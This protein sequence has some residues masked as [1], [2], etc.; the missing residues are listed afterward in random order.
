M[1]LTP[2]QGQEEDDDPREQADNPGAQQPA[3]EKGH[4]ARQQ[5]PQKGAENRAQHAAHDEYEQRGHAQDVIQGHGREPGEIRLRL[6]Q[7]FAL[8]EPAQ[9]IHP[10]LDATGEIALLEA[11][12][13]GFGDDPLGDGIRNR[14]LQAIA[15]L[16]AQ[17]PVVLGHQQQHAVIHPLAP[18]LPGF[19]HPQAELLDGLGLGGG[20]QQHRQLRALGLLQLGQS[21]LQGLPG[22]SVQGASEIGN[23]ALQDRHRHLSPGLSQPQDEAQ[24][25]PPEQSGG[26]QDEA[27]RQSG[28]RTGNKR[29]NEGLARTEGIIRSPRPGARLAIMRARK[30]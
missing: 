16:D 1:K 17:G 24:G 15:H 6:G 26:G 22:S 12:G 19:R 25:Q 5:G 13:D 28:L 18:Q 30:A 20:H 14:P 10:G 8:D 9:S 29:R 21:G 27:I 7:G 4:Q 23:P 3:T 2:H 11:R